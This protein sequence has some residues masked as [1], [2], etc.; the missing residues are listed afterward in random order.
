MAKRVLRL[1]STLDKSG[2]SRSAL[3]ALQKEG[4][5][6]K[7]VKLG[8]TRAVGWLES[9]VDEW[10]DRTFAAPRAGEQSDKSAAA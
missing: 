10:I 6:P 1:R 2:L 7:S 4:A 3:F 8:G 5:F 9:E